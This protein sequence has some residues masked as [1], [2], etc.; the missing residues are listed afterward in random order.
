MESYD[1][2]LISSFYALPAFQKTFGFRTADGSYQVSAS[3]QSALTLVQNVGLIIGIF[4]N[5]YLVDR[6]GSGYSHF[7]HHIHKDARE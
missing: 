1:Q 4:A 6:W 2:I 7:Y 5:T 3:W